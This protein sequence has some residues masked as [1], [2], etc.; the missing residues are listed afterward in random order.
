MKFLVTGAVTI[1]VN[2]EVVADTA[3]QAEKI[4][5]QRGLMSLCHHCSVGEP[6]A[7]WVTSGELDGAIRD[8]RVEDENGKQVRTSKP[9]R[10]RRRAR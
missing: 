1:S 3:E 8:I 7:E 6:E 9:K 10:R 4:A 2:T 5:C